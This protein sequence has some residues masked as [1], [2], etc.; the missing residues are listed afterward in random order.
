MGLAPKTAA[1]VDRLLERD[2][3][4]EPETVLS[5]EASRELFRGLVLLRS[6]D[7]LFVELG[8]SG[9]I[10]FAWTS[11]GLEA[12]QVGVAAAL[13]PGDWLY[14]DLR[15]GGMA[16]LRGLEL[17]EHVQQLLGTGKDRAHGRQLPGLT[18]T[19]HG[20]VVPLTSN[21]GTRIQQA[22]GTAW[23]ARRANADGLAACVLGPSE[24]ERP[25]PLDALERALTLR[26]PLLGIIVGPKSVADQWMWTLAD[27]DVPAALT[28]DA[29]LHSVLA[30][31]RKLAAR[32]RVERIPCV[33]V[34]EE[35][36][37]DPVE[38][39]AQ[40]LSSTGALSAAVQAEIRQEVHAEI[41]EALDGAL[42][43]SRAHLVYSALEAR[44]AQGCR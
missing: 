31:T 7:C 27:H 35:K 23:A 16:L 2:P 19:I 42:G 17:D 12:V 6:M 24:L 15:T 38:R 44:A 4:V 32:C 39:F 10:P 18:G 36:R 25:E 5:Q 11:W 9:R 41:R 13:E 33:V 40:H 20:R 34:C 22:L 8:R 28:D 14:P 29:E 1:A 21:L 26:A 3:L 30:T 37:S 43:Q